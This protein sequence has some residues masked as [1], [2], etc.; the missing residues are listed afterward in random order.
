MNSIRIINILIII[1]CLLMIVYG[2]NKHDNN[3]KRSPS[4]EES[5]ED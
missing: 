5:E 2:N 3:L 4:P 1:S